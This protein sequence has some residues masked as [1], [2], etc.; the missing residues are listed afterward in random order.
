MFFPIIL[1][2]FL[3][4]TV[5][6]TDPVGSS[7]DACISESSYHRLLGSKTLYCDARQFVN[8]PNDR[9][10]SF[11]KESLEERHS[12]LLK[13]NCEPIVF[14]FFGRHSARFPE[15]DDADIYNKHMIQ[16]Q[17]ALRQH[18]DESTCP[19]KVAELFN[20]KPKMQLEHES[21]ITHIGSLE[22]RDIARRFKKLYPQFFDAKQSDIK[23]GVTNYLRTAQTAL[24]FLKEV[25]N[26]DLSSDCGKNSSPIHDIN[27]QKYSSDRLRSHPCYQRMMGAY[28]RRE[29]SFDEECKAI[30]RVKKF[31][32]PLVERARNPKVV[33]SI[34]ESI[35]TRL[36]FSGEN[37]PI[38]FEMLNSMYDNC[39]FETALSEGSIWC[40]LFTEKELKVLE[41]IEDVNTYIKG[42]YGSEA[43]P[44]QSCPVIKD[45]LETFISATHR[46]G[47]VYPQKQSVF[48][49]SHAT[50]M[51]KVLAVFGL[52]TDMDSFSESAISEFERTLKIPEDRNWRISGVCPFSANM[53]FILY[54]CQNP[55]TDR[56]E[57][58]VLS[59]VTERP[60]RLSGC[61]DIVCDSETFFRN[62]EP[63][64]DCDLRKICAKRNQD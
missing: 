3:Q 59:T 33:Q 10:Y 46:S 64:R 38:D 30:M 51:K 26:F 7:E 31:K 49:F 47:D 63:L 27:H 58:K 23:L 6:A 5:G 18:V 57:H 4:Q 34:I 8:S 54:R 2:F 32:Y 24:E 12:Q 9:P 22:Q 62:Y 36:G 40:K 52:F 41:Y 56:V 28:V 55:G 25:D 17:D 53:A 39:R 43:R 42:A 50:P 35:S 44:A 13:R 21:L 29:L 16:I 1:Y 11:D 48:Y 15:G 14:F 19:Q 45:L 37:S 60:V 61:Q 20:W